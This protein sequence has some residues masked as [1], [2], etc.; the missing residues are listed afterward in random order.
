MGND[1]RSYRETMAQALRL[2]RPGVEVETVDPG[3]LDSSVRRLVPDV[4]VCSE[5]TETVRV[6]VPVW[7]ELYPGH[8]SHSVASISGRR[9][10]Y[11]E[12]GLPELLSIVDRA[13][14]LTQ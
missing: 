2:M 4:V 11:A 5:A 7:V 1:P 14:H 3:A 9:E 12:I 13:E 8:G 10:E 6:G